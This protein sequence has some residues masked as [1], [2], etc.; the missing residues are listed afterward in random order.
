[1]LYLGYTVLGK[2]VVIFK[3]SYN[4]MNMVSLQNIMGKI[5]NDSITLFLFNIFKLLCSEF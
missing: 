4:Y 3:L 5:I 2:G 1:M